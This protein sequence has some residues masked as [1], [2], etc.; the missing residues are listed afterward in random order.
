MSNVESDSQY[1][2]VSVGRWV[3]LIHSY[4][5]LGMLCLLG[6]SIML[7]GLWEAVKPEEPVVEIVGGTAN[8]P[9]NQ[10][11]NESTQQKIFVDVA[12][13][14]EK[15]GVY[16]LEPQA[17]VGD[18]LVAA[19]GLSVGADREWVAKNLNLAQETKDGGKIFIPSRD[20][21]N[22]QFSNS[23]LQTNSNK[24]IS[25]KINI[26]TAGQSELETLNGIGVA[27][28]QSIITNRPYGDIDELMGK[29]KIPQSVYDKIKD[30]VTV[31]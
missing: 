10:H 14:V 27:R 1:V 6:V 12:G 19:G 17:R 5:I 13:A 24:Q 30:Q 18:A 20:E 11:T 31:Y 22:N 4:G 2:S 9:T 16:T 28:A 21:N 3:S 8:V 25:N 23:N 15:P 7:Y 29:A 26:N